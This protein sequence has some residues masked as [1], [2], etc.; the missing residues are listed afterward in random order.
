MHG[1]IDRVKN[2]LISP[3]SEW[4]VI[5]SEGG[6]IGSTYSGYVV[7]LGAI[8]A[9]ATFLQYA[10]FG[11][12]AFGIYAKVSV[13]SA[14]SSAI[15]VFLMLMALVYVL[16]LIVNALAP[17]FDGQKNHLNAFKLVGYGM[18]ASMLAS[19]FLMLPGIGFLG[20]FISLYSFYVLYT[21]LPVMMKN[22]PEKTTAYFVVLFI[23]SLVAGIFMA[24]LTSC[25][26][27]KPDMRD[28]LGG[29]EGIKIDTP[30]G[31]VEISAP[32]KGKDGGTVTIKGN[33]GKEFKIE[34]KG[35]GKEGVV[36]INADGKK[37]EI[38]AKKIEEFAKQLE[39]I[40]KQMEIASKDGKDPTAA[41]KALKEAM[42]KANASAPPAK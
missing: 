27:P 29:K 42:E 3:K 6:T 19:L 36:T 39:G 32:G 13:L 22:P 35:D 10:V 38:D 7:I 15:L 34:T 31:K 24:T 40:G 25:F 16:S 4:P 18:T 21:G 23:C 11:I 41:L 8:S 26:M 30:A 12:G 33:D 1:I 37:V 14:L 17:T 20:I 9:V 2:I 5:A 28:L